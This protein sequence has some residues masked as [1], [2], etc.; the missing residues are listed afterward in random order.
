MSADV[1]T[2]VDTQLGRSDAFSMP[3]FHIFLPCCSYSM[4]FAEQKVGTESRPATAADKHPRSD[5]HHYR[6]MYSTLGDVVR[7]INGPSSF[8][9][10]KELDTI[11]GSWK[12]E[13][14]PMP[15][16]AQHCLSSSDQCWRNVMQ[17]DLKLN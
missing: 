17:I 8:F 4:D 11:P 5:D 14:L 10:R 3:H 12:N 6:P 9:A 2:P 1:C 7:S 16:V 13:P 15:L